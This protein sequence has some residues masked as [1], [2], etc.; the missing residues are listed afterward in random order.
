MPTRTGRTSS[1]TSAK[2]FNFGNLADQ[3]KKHR[4]KTGLSQ[5]ELATRLGVTAG[6]VGQWELGLKAPSV[7]RLAKLSNALSVSLEVLL[8]ASRQTGAQD[9]THPPTAEDLQLVEEA[10]RLDVDLHQV[11]AEARRRRWLEDNR[12]ALEDANA[13]LSRYGLWSDG[14]R[15]F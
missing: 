15:Q 13:F 8:G 2:T 5:R 14:R 6:A 10:R 12:G 3:I 11:V 1:H 4:H 7:Q 9:A